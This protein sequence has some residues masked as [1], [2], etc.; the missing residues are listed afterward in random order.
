MIILGEKLLRLLG[1][2]LVNLIGESI[3][4]I[5]AKTMCEKIL[6]NVPFFKRKIENICNEP[7]VH[8]LVLLYVILFCIMI[9]IC[10]CI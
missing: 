2:R 10:I 8:L 9:T 4:G 7:H 6:D 3:L 1:L 5:K